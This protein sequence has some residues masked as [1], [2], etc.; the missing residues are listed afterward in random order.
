MLLDAQEHAVGNR[1]TAAIAR[2]SISMLLEVIAGV[3]VSAPGR[4][5]ALGW[6]LLRVWQLMS[7]CTQMWLH[8]VPGVGVNVSRSSK[9]PHSY[10]LRP[11]YVVRYLFLRDYG[12][13]LL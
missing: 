9:S 7:L 3:G 11:G 5:E 6:M 1:Q 10:R 2:Q 13:G 8:A 4:T 12:T